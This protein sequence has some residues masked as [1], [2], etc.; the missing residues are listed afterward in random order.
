MIIVDRKKAL[1]DNFKC[2]DKLDVI[3]EKVMG[4]EDIDIFSMVASFIFNVSP[5]ECK[6]YNEDYTKN[7]EG[8]RR[9]NVAKCLC[10]NS[11]MIDDIAIKY[12]V[13]NLHDLL[14]EAFPWT[15]YFEIDTD[16]DLPIGREDRATNA[17]TFI[18][19]IR[20]YCLMGWNR[21]KMKDLFDEMGYRYEDTE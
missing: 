17:Y 21:V 13:P 7:E 20:G 11:A 5:D 15:P 3:R 10:L 1:L 6:P 9:R 2:F 12:N 18:T 16:N 4:G 8:T 19:M 14:V